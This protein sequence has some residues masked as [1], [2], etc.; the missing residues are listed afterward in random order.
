[1][2]V[3]TSDFPSVRL[4]RNPWRVFARA[5]ARRMPKGLFDRSLIII[6]AP[7][8]LLQGVVAFV[9]MERH[10]QT[11]TQR[12]SKA[13]TADIAA[14][15]DVIES[16]PQPRE[17]RR[18]RAHCARKAASQHRDPAART[19]SRR[20]S[21][22]VLL[23][24]RRC[25]ARGSRHPDQPAVLDRH[26]RQ[27]QP[28]GDPNSPGKAGCRPARFRQ[29]QFSLRIQQPH[30]PGVDGRHLA[31]PDHRLR[32]I[33]AQPDPADPAARGSSRKLRQGTQSAGRFPHP[34]RPRSAPGMPSPSCRCATASSARSSSAR[35]C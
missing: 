7:M 29:A 32:R 1:M 3:E 9:F 16:Y 8:V 25:P 12:L 21:E 5:V 26:G 10:W 24:S 2:A 28:A 19:V 18:G 17:F 23:H 22:A 11:V 31:V 6:I 4:R 27:L 34:R 13:V 20:R 15:I 14:V 33:P 35:P 30:L